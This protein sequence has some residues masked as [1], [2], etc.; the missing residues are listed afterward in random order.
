MITAKQAVRACLLTQFLTRAKLKIIIF[1]YY[2]DTKFIY[3][4]TEGKQKIKL[5]VNE[6]GKFRYI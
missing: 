1:R 5:Q 3:I 2:P 4:E 6:Y